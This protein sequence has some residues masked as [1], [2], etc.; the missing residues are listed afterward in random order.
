MCFLD[1][2]IKTI[3]REFLACAPTLS[4][5]DPA[6]HG[7]WA[8]RLEAGIAWACT[9]YKSSA[10]EYALP[11]LTSLIIVCIKKACFPLSTSAMIPEPSGIFLATLRL[12]PTGLTTL[13]YP[14]DQKIHSIKYYVFTPWRLSAMSSLCLRSAH[15]RA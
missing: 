11:N 9:K 15:A 13:K 8:W 6:Y 5:K 14:I 1:R 10:P 12:D 3:E 7:A 2:K 4:Q